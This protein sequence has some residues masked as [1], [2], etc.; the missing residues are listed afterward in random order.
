LEFNPN[1]VRC[2]IE[3]AVEKEIGRLA[4]QSGGGHAA[5]R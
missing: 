4:S 3:I 1:G 2:T 5:D